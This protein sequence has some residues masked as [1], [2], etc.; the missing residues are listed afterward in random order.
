MRLIGNTCIQK[1]RIAFANSSPCEG[2]KK[3]GIFGGECIP[4]SQLGVNREGASTPMLVRRGRH[5]SRRW[6]VLR[7]PNPAHLRYQRSKPAPWGEEILDCLLGA[8]TFARDVFREYRD[9]LALLRLAQVESHACLCT[10]LPWPPFPLGFL[11]LWIRAC[12]GAK[13][14]KDG[15]QGG[16]SLLRRADRL[17]CQEDFVRFLNRELDA[18]FE[19]ELPC[20]SSATPAL[21]KLPGQRHLM[22]NVEEL[23]VAH[24]C[25]A[26]IAVKMRVRQVF[27]DGF[28]QRGNHIAQGRDNAGWTKDVSRLMA[29]REVQHRC[30]SSNAPPWCRGNH[31]RDSQRG[32]DRPVISRPCSSNF[33]PTSAAMRSAASR[34]RSA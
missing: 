23:A 21:K 1:C 28:R 4:N 22:F 25:V 8:F 16:Q 32:A 5:S 24:F 15:L 2:K 3:P 7:F 17:I 34:F 10:V 26:G 19:P 18:R 31:S 20:E 12:P 11:R 6:P 14:R 27:P 29:G 30:G 33:Q 13:V 9:S